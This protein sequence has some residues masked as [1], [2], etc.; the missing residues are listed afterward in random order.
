MEDLLDENE[1]YIEY[2]DEVLDNWDN[3]IGDKLEK[4]ARTP[5]YRKGEM[6]P[7]FEQIKRIQDAHFA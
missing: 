3:N 6:G 7:I 1:L 2:S 4:F 5:L